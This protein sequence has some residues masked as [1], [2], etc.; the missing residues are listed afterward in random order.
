M[1]FFA[2]FKQ[3]FAI[4]RAYLV[5]TEVLYN[6]I[7]DIYIPELNKQAERVK[8][9][10]DRDVIYALIEEYKNYANPQT[11]Q[12]RDLAEVTER[13]VGSTANKYRNSGIVMEDVVQQIAGDF[14]ANPRMQ[15]ALKDFKVEGGPIKMR[16]YWASILNRHSEFQFREAER[17]LIKTIQRQTEEGVVIDDPYRN[18]PN[19]PTSI[20]VREFIERL[21][22]A[23]PKYIAYSPKPKYQKEV[24]MEIFNIW[25]KYLLRYE[26]MDFGPQEVQ[27]EWEKMKEKKGE[28][29]SRSGWGEGFKIL[30]DAIKEHIIE[31]KRYQRAAGKTSAERVAKAEFRVRFAKWILGE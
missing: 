28:A 31:E 18:I 23:V 19:K 15:Q 25:S 17:K 1:K 5:L 24:A 3:L 26:N 14:Y 6:T 22:D 8:N 30:K 29:I 4:D 12:G 20:D 27:D 2:F 13:T 10:A 21:V 11:A 9:V 16:N 7:K